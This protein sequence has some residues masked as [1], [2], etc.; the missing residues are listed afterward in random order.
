VVSEGF[1]VEPEIFTPDM[2]GLN[3]ILLISYRF[4][5]PGLRVRILVVDPR[6]RLVQEIAAGALLGTEGFFTWDG[7]DRQGRRARAGLYLVLAEVSGLDKG[8]KRYK[9]TCVLS[10]GH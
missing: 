3:D 1:E 10:I 7:T 5:S 9:K 2:D 4:R 8:I 6:G